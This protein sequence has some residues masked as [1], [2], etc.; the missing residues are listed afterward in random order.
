MGICYHCG[1]ELDENRRCPHCNLTFCPEHMPQKEHN[2]I[3]LSR[4]FKV[5]P[6]AKREPRG[7]KRENLRISPLAH[8]PT[9]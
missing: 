4:E 9:G 3:A 1:K 7:R 5:K 2:C 6:G 8:T